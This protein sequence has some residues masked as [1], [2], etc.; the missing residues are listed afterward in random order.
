M[1]QYYLFASIDK[2]EYFEPYDYHNLAKLLEHGYIATT[3]SLLLLYLLETRWKDTRVVVIGDYSEEFPDEA[4]KILSRILGET[5]FYFF[6]IKSYTNIIPEVKDIV[7]KL[8]NINSKK[9]V[10]ELYKNKVFVSHTLKEYVDL[11]HQ[12]KTHFRYLHKKSYLMLNPVTLLLASGNGLGGGDYSDENLDYAL[13]GRFRFNRVGV[14]LKK[15]IDLSSYRELIPCFVEMKHNHYKISP[16]RLKR[17]LLQKKKD[18]NRLEVSQK[19]I[20]TQLF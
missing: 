9:E 20:Q 19:F 4:T 13:V 7:D 8:S 17:I 16:E 11:D 15:E 10:L 14:Y 2:K 6:V 3:S 18:K 5:E 1:G 12:V